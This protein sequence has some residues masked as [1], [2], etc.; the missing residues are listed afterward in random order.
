V[1]VLGTLLLK[2][3]TFALILCVG[4]NGIDKPADR[5]V[6]DV[7][8]DVVN[9]REKV[10]HSKGQRGER[11]PLRYIHGKPWSPGVYRSLRLHGHPLEIAWKRAFVALLT[12]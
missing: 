7:V 9:K 10:G 1:P 2:D 12:L 11:A 5:G 3:N 6:N 8:D 4:K